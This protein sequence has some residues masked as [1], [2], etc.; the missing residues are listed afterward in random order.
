MPL[1]FFIFITKHKIYDGVCL[2][3]KMLSSGK[4]LFAPRYI[5]LPA[6]LMVILPRHTGTDNLD[7]RASILN[8]M[9]KN[10]QT[11]RTPDA[12]QTKEEL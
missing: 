10:N 5:L 7:K 3:F 6:G 12:C 8:S 9:S 1:G 11:S 2:T 4:G